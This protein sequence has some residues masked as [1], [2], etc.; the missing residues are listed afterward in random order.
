MSLRRACVHVQ[1]DTTKRKVPT[2][3]ANSSMLDNRAANDGGLPVAAALAK[4]MHRKHTGERVDAFSMS[5]VGIA[6]F[7]AWAGS[8]FRSLPV[9][10]ASASAGRTAVGFLRTDVV[11]R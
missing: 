2:T 6:C 10:M 8:A 11:L 3:H 7:L 5:V 4:A 9:P 1:A